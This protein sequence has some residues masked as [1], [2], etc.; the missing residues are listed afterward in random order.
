M[1]AP[2]K[3]AK[4]RNLF[5]LLQS[6]HGLTPQ[7]DTLLLSIIGEGEAAVWFWSVKN[8][9]SETKAKVALLKEQLEKD[10]SWKDSTHY[11]ALAGMALEKMS[12]DSFGVVDVELWKDDVEANDRLTSLTSSES[13]AVLMTDAQDLP[14]GYAVYKLIWSAS[15]RKRG[16][17]RLEI[18]IE[19][20][21]IAPAL[22]GEGLGKELAYELSDEIFKHIDSLR[23][24]LN[25]SSTPTRFN[26][27]YS[28]EL[29]SDSGE[30]FL[31]YC[32][33]QHEIMLRAEDRYGSPTPLLERKVTVEECW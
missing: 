27:T 11:S 3:S 23:E 6:R 22:R 20:V 10:V 31:N 14:V 2:L 5:Q 18:E 16:S 17:H 29:Y 25:V 32:S 4:P 26:V 15:R 30:W 33:Y 13:A 21:W 9:N 28:G 1:N 7:P 8:H 19:E 12:E 24:N